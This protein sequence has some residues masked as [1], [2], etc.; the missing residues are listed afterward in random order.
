MCKLLNYTN[1]AAVIVAALLGVVS[2]SAHSQ[3]S[4]TLYGMTDAGIIYTNKT[5]NSA[6]RSD[7]GHQ[8]SLVSGGGYASRFGIKGSEDLGGG[9]EAIFDLESGINVANGGFSD[10]NGNFF[11]R[12]A[13]V[14]MTGDFGTAKAGVQY[15][16][17][18]LSIIDSDPRSA[19]YFGS[20]AVIYVDNVLV[21]G[22][23]NSNAISYTSPEVGG[24]QGSAMLA[25]GG[26]SDFQGG[27][28]YS[29]ALNYKH[30]PFQLTAAMYSGNSGGTAASTPTPSTVAFSGRTIGAG[31]RLGD[32]TIKA[33]FVEYKVAGS[34][35]SHVYSAGFSYLATPS[36]NVDAGVW[37]VRDGNDADNHSVMAATGVE[38][39]LSKATSAYCQ[40][41]F[42]NNHGHMKNG[43]SINGAL[44]GTE[45]STV[46]AIVG[47]RHFF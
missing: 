2:M 42:L 36:I 27:R 37:V 6:T 14:G 24:L 11:G 38:Y 1:K 15:S 41:A 23:F 29:A 22:I 8:W 26:T 40:V 43:L 25:L 10:S 28:Q 31:Y 45:G 12:R 33:A 19:S 20:A 4:V 44:Y 5:L 16:P 3:G 13:W 35:D 18:A 30:G 32:W 47:I 9:T 46:G 34:F 17:F 21:T 7:A 39:F